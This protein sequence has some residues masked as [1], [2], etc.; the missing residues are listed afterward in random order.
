MLAISSQSPFCVV[1]ENSP[2]A[3]PLLDNAT[4][5]EAIIAPRG[6]GASPQS[7]PAR[8]SLLRP[9]SNPE[10][11]RCGPVIMDGDTQSLLLPN[12]HHEFLAPCDALKDANDLSTR[13][14]PIRSG[15]LAKGKRLGSYSKS[16]RPSR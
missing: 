4:P 13:R 2:I 3:I 5:C 12:E 8:L 15:Y 16:T 14:K 6:R 7:I 10:Y 9:A 1:G 11:C